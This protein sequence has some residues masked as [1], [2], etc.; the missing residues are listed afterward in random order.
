MSPSVLRQRLRH[1]ERVGV[2]G[3]RPNPRGRRSPYRLTEAGLALGEVVIGLGTW[4]QRW[5]E[6]EHRHLDA[7]ALA[8]AIFTRL[9]RY[10]LPERRVVVKLSFH[11]QP[12]SYWLLL[13]REQPEVCFPNPGLAEDL[14]VSADLETMT[15]AFLGRSGSRTPSP[16]AWSGSGATPPWPAPSRPGRGRAGSR[17][18]PGRRPTT[19]AG[20]AISRGRRRR[21]EGARLSRDAG[22]VRRPGRGRAVSSPPRDG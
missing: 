22:L 4:G 9:E 8:W 7:E 12:R 13:S 19:R 5:L 20:G 14:E 11:A 2:V 3:R 1:L 18:T 16:V 6:P 15:R 21:D 17:S 10:R